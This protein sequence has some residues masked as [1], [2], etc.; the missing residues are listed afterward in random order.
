MV[1]DGCFQVTGA[2]GFLTPVGMWWSGSFRGLQKR[3]FF[4]FS[5]LLTVK[6]LER[7]MRSGQDE[8]VAE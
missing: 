6:R 3:S 7:V 2:K 4:F 1:Y 5:L 8:V